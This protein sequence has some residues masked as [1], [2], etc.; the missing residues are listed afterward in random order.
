MNTQKLTPRLCAAARLCGGDFIADVGTDHGFLPIYLVQ[1]GKAARAIASDIRPEPLANARENIKKY[2]LT[3][4]VETVLTNGLCGLEKYPL[5][6]IVI[7]GMGGMNIIGILEA[8]PFVRERGIRLVLQPMQN[9]CELSSFLADNGYEITAEEPVVDGG[10]AYRVIAA[11]Y[12]GKAR[13]Y[14]A[15]ELMLG[16]YNISHKN[17]HPREFCALC[18][19]F[20]STTKKKIDGLITSGRTAE[21]EKETLARLLFHRKEAET[22]LL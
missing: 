22:W 11:H 14:T 10:K 1:S 15:D 8:A 2:E 18:D 6:D 21:K 5:T 20:I 4:A 7:A 12:D 3:D 13:V 17:E 9:I 19:K 16:A